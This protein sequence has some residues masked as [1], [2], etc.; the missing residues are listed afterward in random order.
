MAKNPKPCRATWQGQARNAWQVPTGLDDPTRAANLEQNMSNFGMGT[1]SAC[2]VISVL[3]SKV[4]AHPDFH[5]VMRLMLNQPGSV[6]IM[7]SPSLDC[8]FTW[9]VVGVQHD[10]D[11]MGSASSSDLIVIFSG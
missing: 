11:I 7:T 6:I 8:S 4:M 3:T 9:K 5:G 1:T 10:V 2:M